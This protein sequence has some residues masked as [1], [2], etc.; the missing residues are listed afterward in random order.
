MLDKFP[1]LR[2]GVVMVQSE[3]ADRL[4]ASPNTRT[5]GSPTVKAK[6]WADL[7]S[8]GTV[9]RSVF[10]PIPNVDSSLVRFVRHP[11][12]GNENLRKMTF[13]LVDA[14]FAHRRKMLRGCLSEIFGGS[15]KAIFTLE[16]AGI[17]PTL[18]GEA[19]ALEDFIKIAEVRGIEFR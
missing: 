11:D 2:T 15:D 6:W 4:V 9:A 10:W 3:V 1:T 8:A 13:A 19:L 5:Y 17:D 16:F 14:A 12:A 18:R 7:T